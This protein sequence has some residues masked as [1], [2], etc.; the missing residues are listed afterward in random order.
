[1][2]RVVYWSGPKIATEI[3]DADNY[4]VDNGMFDMLDKEGNVVLSI[5]RS[6][7]VSAVRLSALVKEE[8]NGKAKSSSNLVQIVRPAGQINEQD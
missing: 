8:K 5:R 1:M 4:E 3:L 2:F 7:L 6:A